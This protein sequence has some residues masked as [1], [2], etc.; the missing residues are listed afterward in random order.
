MSQTPAATPV[1]PRQAL[2]TGAVLLTIWQ[3]GRVGLQALWMIAIARLL[4]A[5]SYGAFAGYAGLASALGAFTGVGFGLTLLQ[6]VSRERSRFGTSLRH[7]ASATLVSGFGLWLLFA[8]IANLLLGHALPGVTLACIGIA[9]IV[10]FPA[11]VL[12]SYAYQAHE[13]PGMAGV[14]YAVV[15]M[16][17]LVAVA[18]FALLGKDGSLE[19]Y[20]PFH[21]VIAC[22]ASGAAWCVMCYQLRPPA[23][24]RALPTRRE[25]S[26]SAS[27]SLMRV[28]DTAMVS[29]DKS[30]VLRLA[31][32]EVA[33]WYTVAFRLVSVLSIPVSALAMAALPRLFRSRGRANDRRLVSGL[34]IAAIAFGAL[35][36]GGMLAGAALL[37]WL[38][39]PSFA[40]AAHTAQMLCLAPLLMG[41]TAIGA[42]VLVTSD[43]RVL[44][45][46]AQATGLAVLC[47]LAAALIPRYGVLGAAAMLQGALAVTAALLWL[48]IFLRPN[49]PPEPVET[50]SP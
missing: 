40:N 34:L 14:M 32:A 26:E 27:Y 24:D 35:G 7:A 41:L 12:S 5:A 43:R 4:G 6:E 3:F 15:P 28:I 45:V 17:N 31:G 19:A 50:T 48:A 13:R 1:T 21:A 46:A 29:L 9:E 2:R 39:G 25:V 47:G 22:A 20:A 36:G 10:A 11:T 44:R 37:P 8:L 18:L 30:L 42:N 38:L 16:G 23:A 33:G 49:V